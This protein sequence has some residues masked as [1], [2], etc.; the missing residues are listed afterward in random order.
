MANMKIKN[1]QIYKDLKLGITKSSNVNID[2]RYF[3]GIMYLGVA[4]NRS[5]IRVG[6]VWYH[7]VLTFYWDNSGD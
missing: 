5:Q 4:R 7:L 1:K 2:G 6:L 3:L